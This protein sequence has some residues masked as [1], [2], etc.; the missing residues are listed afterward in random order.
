MD[1][2]FSIKRERYYI[3]LFF[4]GSWVGNYDND[5]EIEEAKLEILGY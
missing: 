1:D 3:T 2:L 5:K 4:L